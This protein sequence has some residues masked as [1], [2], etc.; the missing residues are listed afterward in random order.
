MNYTSHCTEGLAW[1]WINQKIYWTDNCDDD[2]EV[3][4]PI[5]T[6]RRVLFDTGLI[7]PYAIVVD[8]TTGYVFPLMKYQEFSLYDF[9]SVMC[10]CKYLI[11]LFH[12]QVDVLD[13]YFNRTNRESING[14]KQQDSTSQYRT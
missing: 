13:R 3:Y 9:Y 8:P 14:W 7:T 6:Y 5:T 4:D 2:I 1:D 11:K 12:M 10:K